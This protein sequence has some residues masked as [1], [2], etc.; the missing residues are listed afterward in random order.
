MRLQLQHGAQ[1]KLDPGGVRIGQPGEGGSR[2]QIE[3]LEGAE[4][5]GVGGQRDQSG[6]T[7]GPGRVRTKNPHVRNPM[8]TAG[9]SGPA[10]AVAWSSH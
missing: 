4:T 3:H 6:R 8:A 9:V 2:K 5:T 7:L 10:V 1:R